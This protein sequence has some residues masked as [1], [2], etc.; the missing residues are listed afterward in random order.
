MPPVSSHAGGARGD[1]G[2]YKRA[3]AD[4]GKAIA[5]KPAGAFALTHRARTV[6]GRGYMPISSL[7]GL[8]LA[9]CLMYFSGSALNASTH[10]GQ[11]K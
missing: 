10:G 3:I 7:G 5:L 8:G 11:Q 6:P 1:K 4:F 9:G 2:D